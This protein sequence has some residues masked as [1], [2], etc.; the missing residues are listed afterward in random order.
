MIYTIVLGWGLN[1]AGA[2]AMT[3]LLPQFTS[4][5]PWMAATAYV[6]ILGVLVAWRFESGQW[7]KIDLLDMNRSGRM[8]DGERW[9]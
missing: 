4:I 8:G 3:Q 7:R 6:I 2:Y 5:G 9:R 1:V